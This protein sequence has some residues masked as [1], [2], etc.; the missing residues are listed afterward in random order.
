[1]T[2]DAV[3]T[4]CTTVASV[5]ASHVYIRHI[6]SE[7][8]DGVRRLADPAPAIPGR[9]VQSGWWPPRMLQQ[10]WLEGHHDFDVFHVHFGFDAYSPAELAGV[11]DLLRGRG[12][13]LVYTVHDL[14]NP[15]QPDPAVHDALLDILIPAADG[16]ITLTDGAAAEIAA[17]WNREATVIPHPHVVDLGTMASIVPTRGHDGLFRA[18]LHVKSLRPN[19]NPVPVVTALADG[20]RNLPDAILQV[21]GHP[22]VLHPSGAHYDAELAEL[23]HALG[24]DGVVDLRI[25]DYFTEAELWAY[26]ASLD[27]SVLPYR[28]GTHSGW[29]EACRDLGTAVLAPDCGYYAD[30]GHVETFVNNPSRFDASSVTDAVGRAFA[31]GAP[32]ALT[33]PERRAQRARIAAAHENLYATLL[34]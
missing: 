4:S 18:G 19:M 34:A 20:I 1:V 3:R 27:V 33:V 22:D 13:P 30:Q 11:V 28:F 32:A 8:D 29:L 24:R 14:R 10:R 23:L 31:H 26:L 15:H 12:V 17:R 25:T 7:T 16:L 2:I 21:N 5:P 9:S 6:A